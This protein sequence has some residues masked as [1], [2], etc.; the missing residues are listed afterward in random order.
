MAYCT[1]ANAPIVPPAMSQCRYL[2]GAAYCCSNAL[3][4]SATEAEKPRDPAT[5]FCTAALAVAVPGRTPGAGRD[6]ALDTVLAT[7]RAAED[8]SGEAFRSDAVGT[9]CDGREEASVWIEGK[10]RLLAS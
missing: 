8:T 3:A 7:A 1:L 10:T 2:N 6:A 9:A 4:V 5:V